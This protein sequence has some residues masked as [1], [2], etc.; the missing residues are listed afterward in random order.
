[1]R[2]SVILKRGAGGSSTSP[3]PED[4][5]SAAS[6]SAQQAA[7]KERIASLSSVLREASAAAAAD[8]EDDKAAAEAEQ[9]EQGELAVAEDAAFSTD[10]TAQAMLKK[11]RETVHKSSL[12]SGLRFFLSRE[13]PTESLEFCVT[14]L[15]GTVARSE[16]DASI[17]HHVVDRPLKSKATGKRVR[18][19]CLV[20]LPLCK[21]CPFSPFG[22]ACSRL[23]FAAKLITR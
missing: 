16:T 7:S 17:T 21:V 15:G 20:A 6:E 12:F 13:V 10:A 9:A 8:E 14:A 1:M 22:P 18:C 19:V 11:H 5:N 4:S 2:S 23:D 3:A